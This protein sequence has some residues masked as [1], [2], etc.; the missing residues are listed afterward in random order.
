MREVLGILIFT[1]FIP[2]IFCDDPIP[3]SVNTLNL[4]L[5][6]GWQK[7]SFGTDFLFDAYPTYAVDR[8]GGIIYSVGGKEKGVPLE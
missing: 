6:V 7:E 1:S 3:C 4:R 2:L 5:E 8:D